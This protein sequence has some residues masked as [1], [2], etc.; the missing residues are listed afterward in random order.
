VTQYTVHLFRSGRVWVSQQP[1]VSQDVHP[2]LLTATVDAGTPIAA[3]GKLLLVYVDKANQP[4]QHICTCDAWCC[5]YPCDHCH[6]PLS[7]HTESDGHKYEP[8]D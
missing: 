6:K 8:H 2:P 1:T 7:E 5:T 4:V 3:L